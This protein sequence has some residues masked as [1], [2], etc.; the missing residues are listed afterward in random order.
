MS[1]TTYTSNFSHASTIYIVHDSFSSVSN[2]CITVISTKGLSEKNSDGQEKYGPLSLL[3]FPGCSRWTLPLISPLA[4]N[5]C[6]P[7]W[8]L[9]K[10]TACEL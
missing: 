4:I 7:L 5:Y 3:S 8:T 6:S 10:S 2:I 1:L 9:F